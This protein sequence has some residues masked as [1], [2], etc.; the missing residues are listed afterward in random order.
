MSQSLI[1]NNREYLP[2]GEVGKHFGY[3]RDYILTLTREEK[4]DGKKIG[5]RWYVNLESATAFFE[6]AKVER[7]ARRQVV[8]QERKAELRSSL[9][10]QP[11]HRPSNALLETAAILAIGLIVGT[12]GYIGTGALNQQAAVGGGDSFLKEIAVAFYDFISPQPVIT[13]TVSTLPTTSGDSNT[14]S[15]SFDQLGTT[16]YTTLVVGDGEVLTTSTI[17]SIRDSFSDE[18]SVSIDPH[19]PDTGIIIPYFKNG[20]GE[21]YRYLIVPVT[22][23]DN[24]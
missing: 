17:S 19:N 18:V 10:A 15:T 16:T 9:Y 1:I 2:A 6:S 7:E 4:I 23:N 5:H 14:V 21:E 13:T 24:L 3:T 20:N 12:S 22:Q 8:S 11:T